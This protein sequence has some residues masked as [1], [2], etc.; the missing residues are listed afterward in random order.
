MAQNPIGTVTDEERLIPLLTREDVLLV[1]VTEPIQ[2]ADV[3]EEGTFTWRLREEGD[4]PRLA[5]A[6][7]DDP[8]EAE[9]RHTKKVST[10]DDALTIEVPKPLLVDGLGLDIEKYDD[11]NP[12]LFKPNEIADAVEVGII[13]HNEPS[14]PVG[15][16]IELVPMRFADGTPYRDEPVS[17]P[18]MDSDPVAQGEIAHNRGDEATPRSE[19][20]SAP[21]DAAFVD[22]V[23]E[24]TAVPRTEVVQA[25]ESISRYDLVSEADDDTEYEPLAVDDRVVIGLDDDT[26]TEKVA[27]ELD[28]NDATIKAIR[29]IHT[30]QANDLLQRSGDDQRKFEDHIPVVIQPDRGFENE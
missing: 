17:E 22:E 15:V 10:R 18:S 12:L 7:I 24:T 2:I 6:P 28:S 4:V 14:G 20:I 8:D 19:T 23:L 21:I 29:E 5:F 16:A 26:W 1:D 9:A 30:R 25:L 13:P 3:P 11:D 27:Q